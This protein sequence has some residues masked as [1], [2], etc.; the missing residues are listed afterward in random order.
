MIIVTIH[1]ISKGGPFVNRETL[2]KVSEYNQGTQQSQITDKPLHHVVG[3]P[4]H[5]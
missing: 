4:E 1:I 2:Q 5:K 3:R